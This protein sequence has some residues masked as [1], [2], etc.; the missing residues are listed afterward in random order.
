MPTPNDSSPTDA[1]REVPK[2][3]NALK[4]E[5][6]HNFMLLHREL[7]RVTGDQH[8]L[9]VRAACRE[10]GVGR[11]EDGPLVRAI[12]RGELQCVKVG[13]RL[14]IRKTDLIRWMEAQARPG[15]QAR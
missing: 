7:G 12:R 9:S 11:S 1:L 4:S 15:G 8:P 3:L 2:T 10:L 5:V 13:T 14:K 6:R